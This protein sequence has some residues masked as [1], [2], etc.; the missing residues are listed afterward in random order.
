MKRV[1]EPTYAKHVRGTF[2][3]FDDRLTGFSRGRV[4]PAGSKYDK[5]H[6]RSVENIRKDIKGKTV[7]D[8][9]L[10]VA[11]RTVDYVMRR[12][13]YGREAL[14]QFNREFKAQDRSPKEMTRIVKRVARWLGADLV[15]VARLNRSWV[16][17]HWGDQNAH[18]CGAAQAGDPIEI[19]GAFQYVIVLVQEMG[20]DMVKRSP[21][22]EADTDLVY[23]TM[24]FTACSLATYISEIGYRAIPSVNELGIDV[25]F[26]VDAGLGEMGRMGLLMTREFGP[27]CRIGKVFTDIPLEPDQPI[28]IGVQGFCEKCERCSVHCPSGAIKS[29]ARTEEP[30]DESNNRGMLKWP[31]HAMKCL[32]WWV[33]NGSHCSVCVRVCPWNKPNTLFHRGVRFLAERDLFTRLLVWMD[34]RMG[35][36]KQSVNFFD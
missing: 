22:V 36:G 30:W 17:S 10:W 18:Y 31:V 21:A 25:A 7:L 9:G 32:D 19:P 20:Y 4:D 2:K 35:Y 3:Q 6:Q 8:H 27:R 29:G 15:G 26:A 5:M 14:A 23:A 28:D 24:G 34:E 1:N 12:N 13:Q 11:G 33:K 16:Y